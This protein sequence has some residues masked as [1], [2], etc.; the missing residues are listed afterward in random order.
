M[1]AESEK[2]ALALRD[3]ML[4]MIPQEA[5]GAYLSHNIG[6]DFST[7]PE[8]FSPHE[9]AQQI[10]SKQNSPVSLVSHFADQLGPGATITRD[11]FF[12]EGVKAATG[13]ERVV[14]GTPA[15]VADFL[16][17]HFDGAGARGGYMISHPHASPRDLVSIVDLLIPELQR[18]GRF[19]RSYTK[20][21]LM[22]TLAE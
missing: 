14:A 21:T 6:Y 1:V 11:E 4:D 20:K 19:R 18:R 8:R 7:L 22:E 2:D 13:Y 3:R 9:L 10:A 12:R 16:E 5:V 17:E 15:K